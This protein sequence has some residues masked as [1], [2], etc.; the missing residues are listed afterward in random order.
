MAP[1]ILP[2]VSPCL[3]SSQAMLLAVVALASLH[4]GALGD[5]IMRKEQRQQH[6]ATEDFA[7]GSGG[8]FDPHSAALTSIDDALGGEPTQS[9]ADAKTQF[10]DDFGADFGSDI[11]SILHPANALNDQP[12]SNLTGGTNSNTSQAIFNASSRIT[13][14]GPWDSTRK[15]PYSSA[16]CDDVDGPCMVNGGFEIGMSGQPEV[17]GTPDGWVAASGTVAE[18]EI[19]LVRS[20]AGAWADVPTADG[21]Y[22][23]ALKGA[24]TGVGTKMS[25]LTKYEPYTLGFQVSSFTGSEGITVSIDDDVKLTNIAAPVGSFREVKLKFQASGSSAQVRFAT[26]DYPIK[27]KKEA[28]LSE[29][30]GP[31]LL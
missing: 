2:K 29:Q 20:G 16:S 3:L 26:Y 13:T 12:V 14:A 6:W 7:V 25:G 28:S 1:T 15:W 17:N 18:S 8:T 23:L 22:F 10:G 9:V 31:L 21:G 5:G 4:T 24:H 19:S 11:S 27:N 30:G